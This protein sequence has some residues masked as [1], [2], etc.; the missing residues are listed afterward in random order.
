VVENIAVYERMYTPEKLLDLAS[1]LV[2]DFEGAEAALTRPDKRYLRAAVGN[3]I[4]DPD[5]IAAIDKVKNVYF[6]FHF[7]KTFLKNDMDTKRPRHL[8]HSQERYQRYG[9]ART[10]EQEL[11]E[12]DTIC[13]CG[14][15]NAY[16]RAAAFRDSA[17]PRDRQRQADNGREDFFEEDKKL[18]GVMDKDTTQE[19]GFHKI[20]LE[21]LDFV[22]LYRL[23]LN[24]AIKDR[25]LRVPL[26]QGPTDGP[27]GGSHRLDLTRSD[28]EALVVDALVPRLLD[29][30]YVAS[31]R[32]TKVM[33]A[34]VF[35]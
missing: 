29:D 35:E 8:L 4:T 20:Y 18:R 2:E 7:K 11:P 25:K 28:S 30:L 33:M 1:A 26:G 5:Q 19:R 21:V 6:L 9:I 27:L 10:C 16:P 17:A 24:K 22:E 3:E 31:Q 32:D 15:H 13:V 34:H 23:H 14:R 12:P